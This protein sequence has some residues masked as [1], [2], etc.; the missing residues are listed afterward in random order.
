MAGWCLSHLSAIVLARA[1]TPIPCPIIRR[2]ATSLGYRRGS[3]PKIRPTRRRA[4]LRISRARWCAD[5]AQNRGGNER[6][7]CICRRIA[8]GNIC[9]RFSGAGMSTGYQ[10]SGAAGTRGECRQ[11]KVRHTV[12]LDKRLF[13]TIR[14]SAMAKNRSV[15]EEMVARLASAADSVVE[16]IREAHFANRGP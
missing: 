16:Q 8:T 2:L 14:E 12:T 9:G 11:G 15:S 3:P 7:L 6:S 1:A 13:E 5:D 10:S 4:A